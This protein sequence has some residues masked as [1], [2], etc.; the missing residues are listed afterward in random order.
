MRL[1]NPTRMA[2][3]GCRVVSASG[4]GVHQPDCRDDRVEEEIVER[5]DVNPWEWS[6]SEAVGFSQAVDLSGADRV[7]FCAGQTAIASDGSPPTD[8]GME[9]QLRKAFENLSVVLEA[10]GLSLSDVVR[11]NIYTTDVEEFFTAYP[12]VRTEVMGSNMPAMTLLEIKRLA[13]PM[14]KVE[15]EATAVR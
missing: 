3:L 9:P 5:R 13:F 12:S 15:L 7:L 10:A 8:T 14:L 1:P 6:K 11:L 2:V 4:Q